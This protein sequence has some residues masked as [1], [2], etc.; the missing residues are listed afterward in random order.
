MNHLIV[1]KIITVGDFV[2]ADRW[3]RGVFAIPCCAVLLAMTG[4]RDEDEDLVTADASKT[5]SSVEVDASRMDSSFVC[6]PFP[7]NFQ[8]SDVCIKADCAAHICGDESGPFDKN[9]CLRQSCLDWQ[10]PD[11]QPNSDLCPPGFVCRFAESMGGCAPSELDGC[12]ADDQGVCACSFT[13]DC[14]GAWCV[15]P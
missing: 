14:G 10:Q 12:T 4:C 2:S 6:E 13:T 5:D 15:K 8:N 7:L 9:G 1:S 11:G 3:L